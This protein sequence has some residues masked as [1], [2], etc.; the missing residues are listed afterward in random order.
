MFLRLASRGGIGIGGGGSLGWGAGL[1]VVG[2]QRLAVAAAH[3]DGGRTR[4]CEGSRLGGQ[5][6]LGNQVGLVGRLFG[7]FGL[8]GRLFGLG[9]FGF[10]RLGFRGPWG[11]EGPLGC[12][13]Q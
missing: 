7:Q 13:R 2:W 8:V 1:G 6:R 12:A 9:R 11:W 5:V 10:Q 3:W 4:H